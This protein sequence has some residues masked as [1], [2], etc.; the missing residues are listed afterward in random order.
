M[1]SLRLFD[2]LSVLVSAVVTI[3]IAANAKQTNMN[4]MLL[5]QQSPE[6]RLLRRLF[7]PSMEIIVN[8]QNDR[9][10]RSRH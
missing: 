5:S 1:M 6:F 3:N 9:R 8:A 2:D 10:L 7:L 4:E